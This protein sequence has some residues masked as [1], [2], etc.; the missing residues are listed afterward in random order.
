ME[1][2][3]TR[4]DGT[5]HEHYLSSTSTHRYLAVFL[6]GDNQAVGSSLFYIAA[7]FLLTC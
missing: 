5:L 7:L 6:F 1:L 4:R 3:G 2:F